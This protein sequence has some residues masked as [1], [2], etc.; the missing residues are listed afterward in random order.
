MILVIW[1][2]KEIDDDYIYLALDE[3]LLALCMKKERTIDGVKHLQLWRARLLNQKLSTMGHEYDREPFILRSLQYIHDIT[4]ESTVNIVLPKVVGGRLP[5][6]LV[7]IV[8]DWALCSHNIHFHDDKVSTWKSAK[9]LDDVHVSD[10][11]SLGAHR[12]LTGVQVAF[13]WS[14]AERKYIRFHELEVAILKSTGATFKS[15]DGNE[16]SVDARICIRC[17]ANALAANEVWELEGLRPKN[18]P[19][20]EVYFRAGEPAAR[21][22]RYR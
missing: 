5:N 12:A 10:C 22:W 20:N 15:S 16:V 14:T 18:D 3:H 19:Q 17:G 13:F 2:P 11:C 8:Y 21:K 1:G 7:D 6:E 4:A 9:Y